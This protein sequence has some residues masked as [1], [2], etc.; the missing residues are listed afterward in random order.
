MKNNKERRNESSN[1]GSKTPN[2]IGA[3]CFIA[4]ILAAAMHFITWLVKI[5]GGNPSWGILSSLVMIILYFAVAYQG[6]HYV[7]N[8]SNTYKIIFWIA[9]TV[10]LLLIILPL[11]GVKLFAL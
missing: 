4:L 5:F 2:L 6:Y 11:S 10:A 3:L 1:S 7:K 9:L 8:K